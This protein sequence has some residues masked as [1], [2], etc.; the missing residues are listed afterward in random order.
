MIISASGDELVWGQGEVQE[1]PEQSMPGEDFLHQQLIPEA[2]RG[3][4]S[5]DYNCGLNQVCF[6]GSMY[7][8]T[9]T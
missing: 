4:Q 1:G 5:I 2:Q 3:K 9:L 6:N 8:M 7:S